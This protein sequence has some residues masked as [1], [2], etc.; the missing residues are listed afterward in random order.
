M[1]TVARPRATVAAMAIV[2]RWEWRTFGAGV[3]A[4]EHALARMSPVR[5]EES[6]EVYVLSLRSDAS[7]KVRAGLMDVKHLVQVDADGLEQWMPVMKTPFP[8]SA[9]D[10]GSVLASLETSEP[11]PHRTVSDAAALA[12][13]S[14]DLHAVGVHKRREHH[15]IG[16]CMAE[17]TEM[18]TAEGTART[19]AV[20]AEDPARVAA[21]VRELGLESQP[22]VC[23]AR[24]L[25]ALLGL[26][27]PRYAVV[28][29]GTN[30]VKFHIGERSADGRWRTVVDRAEVTRLGEGLDTEGR[31]GAAP[32]ARTVAAIDLMA[33]EAR[34]HDAEAIVA[35]GTAV[36]RIAPNA[37]EFVDAVRRRCGVEVEIISG[38]EEA[39]LAY[40]AARA[41]LDF[42][43]GSVV[44][45]DT[46]GGS[47][48]FTF[49]EGERV[50]ERFSRNVG[51][52]RLTERHGLDGVVSEDTL[53]TVLAEIAKDLAPLAERPAPD[54]IV[55]MGGAVT[56][57]AA[58]RH[59]LA[60]YDPDVVHGTVL[61]R[62]DIDGQI[63][64]YRT[65]TAEERRSIVGLQPA[66]AEVILAGA[67]VVWTVL[68]ML[69]RETLTVCDRGL[70][71]GL[72]VERFGTPSAPV[73]A[74]APAAVAT[75]GGEP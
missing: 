29:V 47:T 26:R 30:S 54:A 5:V 28:D 46:G 75:L 41:G 61:T 69:G 20:E 45:F 68:E 32:M 70:R 74:A 22:V 35:V 33:V 36:L 16:G 12:A 55:G 17:L 58:V 59:G 42:A 50:V 51:A 1:T 43:A 15:T 57:L 64:R 24:G 60:T 10:A 31:L 6:D 37:A 4:A 44:V 9:D 40:L 25:K 48:Q 67:C 34:R 18:R 56:N 2:P 49:G 39:R 8:L 72:L 73:R 63:E 23:V 52:V 21:A 38:E 53:A 27:A 11:P 13:L 66:R 7:V 65:S 14:P 3:G 62:E 19:I 71:H